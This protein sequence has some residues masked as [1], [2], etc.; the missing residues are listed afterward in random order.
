MAYRN[1]NYA[2]FYVAE[3]FNASALGAHATTVRQSRW[4]DARFR[5]GH[6]TTDILLHNQ[7]Q[8]IAYNVKLHRH[9]GTVC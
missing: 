8:N 7:H 6:N 1:G 5:D 2:A 4:L 9:A 3:P